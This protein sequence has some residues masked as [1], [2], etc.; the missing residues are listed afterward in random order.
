MRNCYW[1]QPS[2]IDPSLGGRSALW[3]SG[4]CGLGENESGRERERG[5]R[6]MNTLPGVIVSYHVCECVCVCGGGAERA[7]LLFPR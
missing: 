5:C 7:H 4:A 1:H 3:V 2:L 6:L